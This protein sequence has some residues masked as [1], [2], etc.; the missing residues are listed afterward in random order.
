MA[1]N[2]LIQAIQGIT[3]I[4]MYAHL[5]DERGDLKLAYTTEG[6]HISPLGYEVIS[7]VLRPILK[8]LIAS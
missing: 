6:L 2:Q 3:Y 4:D 5:I 8:G 1:C 7:D